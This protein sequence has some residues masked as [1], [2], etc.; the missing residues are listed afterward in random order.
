M[1]NALSNVVDFGIIKEKDIIH[2]SA[3]ENAEGYDIIII[4][5]AN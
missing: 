5:K 2:S 1:K 3:P 4:G